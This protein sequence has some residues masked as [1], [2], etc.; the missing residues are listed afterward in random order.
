[1]FDSGKENSKSLIMIPWKASQDGGDG[2][3]GSKRIDLGKHHNGVQVL[4]KL[5]S[6]TRVDHG[7]IRSNAGEGETRC[8]DAIGG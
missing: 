8:M 5:E 3:F 2:C 6:S 7:S 1:M 4:S